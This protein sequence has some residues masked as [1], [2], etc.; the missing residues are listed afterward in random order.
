MSL[1]LR[2]VAAGLAVFGILLTACRAPAQNPAANPTPTPQPVSVSVQQVQRGDI[3]TSLSYTGSVQASQ[4]VNVVPQVGAKIKTLGVDV[5]SAVKAGQVIATLDTS[6][7]DAQVKQAQAGVDAAQAKVNQMEAGPRP[8]AVA[9]AQA[10]LAAAQAKL[11]SLK[12]GG[13]PEAIAQA[14]ANLDA[15]QAKLAQ[16][17]AGPTPE[18]VK[19]AELAVAQAKNTLYSTQVNKDGACNPHNPKYVCDAAQASA[20]AAQTAVDQAQQQL[21]ILT[22]PP[23]KEVLQQ[24]QAAVDAAQQQYLLAKQP[25]TQ[26]DIDQ[27][28]AAVNAA[29]DQVKLAQQPYTD[30]DVKAA[31]A[32]VEQAKA[33]LD[34]A[35]IQLGYATI[36]APVDGVVSE[37]LLDVGS[38]ASPGSP[39]VT[40]VSRAVE[41]T[42]NVEEAKLG[43]VTPDQSASITVAAYP[44]QPFPA[45]VI[46]APPVVDAKSRTAVIRLAPMDPKGLLKPGMFAEVTLASAK[47]SGVLV[48]PQSATVTSN[49]QTAVDLVTN[50]VVKVQSIQV[51]LTDGSN[52]EVASGLNEGQ[53]VVV[54]DKP[55]LRDGDKVTPELVGR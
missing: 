29:A 24:S 52:V 45:K 17:K 35:K 20:N 27:A 44:N 42:I 43:L 5:G 4:Q 54:G 37:K 51:G 33:A 9:Q 12:D 2:Q 3:Q 50:G 53:I 8:E 15:A 16:T 47:H 18:Q 26:H 23:T 32:S 22:S 46:G 38:M 31:E 28:Q 30:Q 14:K 10:N 48:V 7:L 41:I 11:A 34:L 55:A 49:G 21:V 36:T 19:A 6:T 39:I 25:A 1:P 40:L 13:R